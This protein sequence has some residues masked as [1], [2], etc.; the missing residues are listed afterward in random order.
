[1]TETEQHD[2]LCIELLLDHG[3]MS[4]RELMR[5]H[6]IDQFEEDTAAAWLASALQRGLIET[7]GGSGRSTRF[8]LT[9]TGRGWSR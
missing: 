8:N 5:C 9:D 1:M 6:P 2:P 4:A 7:T 3:A